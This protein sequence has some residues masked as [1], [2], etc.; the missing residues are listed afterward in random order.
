MKKIYRNL[1]LSYSDYIQLILA[2]D[3]YRVYQK[4]FIEVAERHH[5]Q[6][7]EFDCK[8]SYDAMV[9]LVQIFSEGAE[10]APGD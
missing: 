8:R 6:M 1:E 3:M 2:L 5:M 4:P 9:R 10:D 7:T